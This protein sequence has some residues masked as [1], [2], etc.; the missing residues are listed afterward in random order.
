MVDF[1]KRIKCWKHTLAY[2]EENDLN[3][4]A[5]SLHTYQQT[6]DPMREFPRTLVTVEDQDS[7]YAGLELKGAGYNPLVLNFADDVFPGGHV[8]MGSGAQEESLF[9]RTNYHQTLHH[10]T[11]FYPLEGTESVYSPDVTVI[12][13]LDFILLPEFKKLSFIAS[14]GLRHPPLT[15]E[16]KLRPEDRTLLQNKIETIFQV[17]YAYGHDSLVLGALGCGAWN[18]PPEE[19]AGVFREVGERWNGVF[20]K[21]VYAIKKN[22]DKDYIVRTRNSFLGICNHKVFTRVLLE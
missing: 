3:P 12:K 20:R 1:E 2:C 15:I 6:A 16:N 7:I 11:G 13:N 19:V 17:G 22:S 14:P 9:R 8:A 4:K 5:S 18:S 21:I 10:G